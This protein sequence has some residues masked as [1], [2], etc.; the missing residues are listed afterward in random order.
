MAGLKPKAL[1]GRM[2]S[3]GTGSV[4]SAMN[5]G[6]SNYIRQNNYLYQF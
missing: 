5:H 2:D 3:S 6:L 1:S 4:E